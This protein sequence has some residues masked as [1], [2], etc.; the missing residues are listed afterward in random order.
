MIRKIGKKTKEWM[1][2]KK[3]LVKQYEEAS[4]MACEGFRWNPKCMWDWNLSIH[5]LD[6]R[7][8]GKSK[9]T[10]SDT[11]L[12]CPSCHNLADHP[13]NVEEKKFNE[14]LRTSR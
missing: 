4:I 13:R 1:D 7:S 2:A 10:F 6:K 5:H 3:I 9:H 11:R 14:V 12:L 8:S